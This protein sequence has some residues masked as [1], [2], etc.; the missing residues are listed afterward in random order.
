MKTERAEA[1]YL[2][3]LNAAEFIRSHGE[4]GGQ[5]QEDYDMPLELYFAEAAKLADR[6][7]LEAAKIKKKYAIDYNSSN[8]I[9][10]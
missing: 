7:E 3:Y 8:I 6:L 1:K 2:A 5:Y 9:N 4:E 10:R